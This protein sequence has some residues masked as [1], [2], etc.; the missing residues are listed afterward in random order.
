[1]REPGQ[2]VY[3]F[4]PCPEGEVRHVSKTGLNNNAARGFSPALCVRRAVRRPTLGTATTTRRVSF[5]QAGHT[6]EVLWTG[7]RRPAHRAGWWSAGPGRPRSG[8][9]QAGVSQNPNRT[10]TC[11]LRGCERRHRLAV[12]R[13][14]HHEAVAGVVDAVEQVLARDVELDAV[15]LVVGAAAEAGREP[16]PPPPMVTTTSVPPAA[17]RLPRACRTPPRRTRGRRGPTAQRR[18]PSCA[19]R[20]PAGR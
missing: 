14:R 11:S 3:A 15:P 20:R 13:R 8:P 5:T 6:A 19:T 16:P 18:A 4:R 12:E 7:Q 2:T 10:P 17:G 1:M 9:G